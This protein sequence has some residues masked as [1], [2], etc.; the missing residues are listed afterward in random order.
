MVITII[1][2]RKFGYLIRFTGLKRE[3]SY[4]PKL[5]INL[6]STDLIKNNCS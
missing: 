5:L 4:A 3:V 1:I 6:L 2:M